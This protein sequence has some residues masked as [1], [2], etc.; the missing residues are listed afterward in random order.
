MR[1]SGILC[2]TLIGLLWVPSVYAQANR[3]AD[4]WMITLQSQSPADIKPR[5]PMLVL[6]QSAYSFRQLSLSAQLQVMDLGKSGIIK[7]NPY[8]QAA[9][10]SLGSLAEDRR[11]FQA[12]LGLSYG[13]Q[14]SRQNAWMLQVRAFSNEDEYTVVNPVF[15]YAVT[16]VW[17]RYTKSHL[18]PLFIGG[19]ALHYTFGVPA[20]TP[21]LGGMMRIGSQS[22]LSGLLPLQIRWRYYPKGEQWSWGLQSQITGGFNRFQDKRNLDTTG[23]VW[24]MRRSQLTTTAFIAMNRKWAV[25]TLQAGISK[26]IGVGFTDENNSTHL[27]NLKAENTVPWLQLKMS[28][29]I[30]RNVK[31]GMTYQV[32]EDI[33]LLGQP[34]W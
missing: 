13:F 5:D 16:G 22:V 21:V 29:P 14:S 23:T 32:E 30:L 17:V 18:F 25:F 15:R 20:F 27:V 4:R 12:G 34:D 9:N 11:V 7:I 6:P 1:P 28:V 31:P 19:G 26:I 2:R 3:P 24:L 33:N 10:L 8:L